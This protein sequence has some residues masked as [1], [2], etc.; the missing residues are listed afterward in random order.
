[1]MAGEQFRVIDKPYWKAWQKRVAD[2]K[3]V[4]VVKSKPKRKKA[5]R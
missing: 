1:M 5:K 3:M 4:K 2:A